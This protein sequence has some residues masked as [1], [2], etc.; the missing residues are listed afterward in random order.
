MKTKSRSGVLATAEAKEKSMTGLMVYAGKVA[1][2]M[3]SP[4]IPAPVR[5]VSD[6]V[7]SALTSYMGFD[8]PRSVSAS[9][10]T[11]IGPSKDFSA[12]SGLAVNSMLS[13]SPDSLPGCVFS[14]T[15]GDDMSIVDYA[16]QESLY[17]MFSVS[18]DKAPG[19]VV[20]SLPV[21]PKAVRFFGGATM[22]T[23]GTGGAGE[24]VHVFT[25]TNC[26]VMTVPFTRWRGTMYY[27]LYCSA[28][29][30]QTCRLRVFFVPGAD[31]SYIPPIT[32]AVDL[33]NQTFEFSGNSEAEFCV[34]FQFPLPYAQ[35]S[36]GRLCIQVLNPPGVVGDVPPTSAPMNFGLFVR[37]GDDLEL[38]D[39]SGLY[40]LDAENFNVT[41]PSYGDLE[42]QSM[43][44]GPDSAVKVAGGPYTNETMHHMSTLLR[45]PSLYYV[46]QMNGQTEPVQD[47]V[48]IPPTWGPNPA[49]TSVS[50][51]SLPAPTT[52]FY[53]SV[54]DP[55]T[56]QPGATA[57]LFQPSQAG[58]AYDASNTGL[59]ALT[60]VS[61]F[62][63]Y[64]WFWRGSLR[65]T[66]VHEFDANNTSVALGM[67]NCSVT[68][69]AGN[70]VNQSKLNVVSGE[71][72]LPKVL[73]LPNVAPFQ[74][75]DPNCSQLAVEVPYKS[76]S[77]FARNGVP[78]A[79]TL[80]C[81]V[82][83]LRSETALKMY[84][85]AGDD[86]RLILPYSMAF[87][88]VVSSRCDRLKVSGNPVTRP[89]LVYEFPENNSILIPFDDIIYY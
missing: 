20:Y 63:Q 9:S 44:V 83:T 11:L 65:Y 64:F 53:A 22:P 40:W 1:Y 13:S 28:S 55:V 82:V 51:D 89:Y 31:A 81:G 54:A 48:V 4:L 42:P 56:K 61:A 41:R 43:I 79:S 17:E 7:V 27:K 74:P 86:F 62:S 5:V 57:Q 15:I 39:P 67:P 78:S 76:M 68:A 16:A 87:A 12:S 18:S 23:L 52:S 33:Y 84:A 19:A 25:P 35:Q 32:P 73:T 71:L 21:N 72:I 46:D 66:A 37:T 36:I 80:P 6:S 24:T 49:G 60:P 88:T 59:F 75:A 30:F 69:L 26:S 58:V 50:F 14:S 10:P 2:G 47:R 45:K 38:A 3:L 85:S 8:Q 29:A 34:P 70:A 77:L